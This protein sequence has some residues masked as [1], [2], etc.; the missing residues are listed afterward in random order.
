MVLR[1]RLWL[2]SDAFPKQLQPT[3][4]ARNSNHHARL[5][6]CSQACLVY[7]GFDRITYVSGYGD[8]IPLAE[9]QM[10]H[11]MR[12]GC[13]Y[14]GLQRLSSKVFSCLV[15]GKCISGCLGCVV[16]LWDHKLK[17]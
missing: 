11:S 8:I 4:T 15:L 7:L 14:S 12:I 2:P 17:R 16:Q 5:G 10:E 1:P 9:N 3:H 13:I 6:R